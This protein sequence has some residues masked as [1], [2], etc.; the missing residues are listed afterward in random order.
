[1]TIPASSGKTIAAM[2][3]N[4][5][6]Q[7]APP[8]GGML[9]WFT[10]GRF[11]MLLLALI[12]LAYPDALVMGRSFYFRDFSFFGYPLAA[13]HK[14]VFWQGQLP[15]WTAYHN[16]GQPFL[17][18]WNTLSLYPGS[19][20]YLL[21]PLPWSLNVFC[22]AHLF[23]AGLGMF[24]LVRYLLQ[25]PLAAAF[26]GLAFVFNGFALSILMWPNN[27]A[28]WGWLPWVV[29]FSLRAWREGGRNLPLAALIITLQLL[30]GGPEII[31]QTWM[32][33]F[34][35]LILDIWQNGWSL[36]LPGRAAL[37]YGLGLALAAIQLLPFL[38]LL[39]HSQRDV[40][41]SSSDWAMPVWGWLNF[42]VPLFNSQAGSQGVF[43][44][45]GHSWV[46]SYYP[47]VMLTL[48]AIFAFWRR[49][50]KLVLGG[51]C[52]LLFSLALAQGGDGIIYDPVRKLIP[53][54]GYIRFPVK[55]VVLAVA[56]LPIIAAVGLTVIW[57]PDAPEKTLR[58]SL[59]ALAALAL[60]MTLLATGLDH[61]LAFQYVDWQVTLPS[62]LIRV[63]LFALTAWL[64]L[65]LRLPRGWK[66]QAG[67]ITG[68]IALIWLDAIMLGQ[69]PNPTAA[70]WVFKPDYIRD[71]LHLPTTPGPSGPRFL[72]SAESIYR[73]R[74]FTKSTGEEQVTY[75]RMALFDNLNLLDHL[76]KLH[77]F[78]SLDLKNYSEL[79]PWYYTEPDSLV[80][81]LHEF[82]G[83]AYTQ[84]PGKAAEWVKKW[85]PA[86]PVTAGQKPV[87]IPAGDVIRL[88][89][90]GR[91]RPAA[92]AY[93]Y[94]G[95][96][97]D[98]SDIIPGQAKV[99]NLRWEHQ[100][101]QFQVTAQ[102]PS[103]VVLAQTYYHPWVAK[104]K[105]QTIPLRPV[106][107]AFTALKV[108]SG[109]HEVELTYEDH[110]FRRGAWISCAALLVVLA[111][112]FFPR[113]MKE[114]TA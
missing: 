66:D 81:P 105:G 5:M 91:F 9:H 73:L 1:M 72:P 7:P 14:E 10:A 21:L 43:G 27:I 15:F 106:N 31:M 8:A 3:A 95:D 94:P 53:A 97:A 16:L 33:S 103:I 63:T 58:R 34:S 41:W 40:H 48:C 77:G 50:T 70:A 46:N 61:Y 113:R 13:Y 82:A 47:G 37:C 60:L 107:H 62:G 59:L 36:R 104:I 39:A 78:Y 69:R 42:F 86:Q 17:A 45:V 2:T 23:W 114:V 99:D 74:T 52:L 55:F 89:G 101:I 67:F 108:P 87:V 49:P 4:T 80:R 92:E 76:P 30:T 109:I 25:H 85:E 20:L 75:A 24:M 29:L 71:E 111:L 100:H 6:K 51:W 11:S 90:E 26:A 18:Q 110:A 65:R 98:L 38:D 102:A 19:L 68:I 83:F 28:A 112:F 12:I 64:L 54:L 57:E 32:L 84:P 93:F 88:L 96:A 44:Q 22:L 35:F 56:I 79:L